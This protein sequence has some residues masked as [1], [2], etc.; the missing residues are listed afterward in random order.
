[1]KFKRYLFVR[2]EGK[3][4]GDY[5]RVPLIP[6][7]LLLLTVTLLIIGST[8][9]LGGGDK[10]LIFR[11]ETLH[12]L[13][14]ENRRLDRI[15]DSLKEQLDTT[16]IDSRKIAEQAESLRKQAALPKDQESSVVVRELERDDLSYT[17]L[18]SYTDTLTQFLR[19]VVASSSSSLWHSLPTIAPVPTHQAT[20][21]IRFGQSF[22]NF[23]GVSLKNRGITFAAPKGTAVIA[24][25][26]GT[27]R[28]I[29]REGQRGLFVEIDHGNNCITRYSHLETATI[30][31]GKTVLKGQ[32]IG[33]VGESG[34]S[35]GPQLLY[36]ITKNGKPV[37]P[38]PLI[39]EG[40]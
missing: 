36:E 29:G 30:S 33:K 34:W 39:K 38:S 28:Q 19:R 32:T 37:D 9:W 3:G 35:V 17:F 27:I 8:L 10:P 18:Q 20:V 1:M 16:S 21:T 26:A 5:Y 23:S 15:L 14:E 22:D 2:T 12:K 7:I 4:D 6:L 31:R 11:R 24:T 40:L 13:K 25:A